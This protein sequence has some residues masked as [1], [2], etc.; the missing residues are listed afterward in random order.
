M[1]TKFIFKWLHSVFFKWLVIVYWAL[2][3]RERRIQKRWG[4]AEVWM[5]SLNG[6]SKMKKET[7]NK[8]RCKILASCHLHLTLSSPAP[9]LCLRILLWWKTSGQQRVPGM[10][11]SAAHPFI[12][13]SFSQPLFTL[14]NSLSPISFTSIHPIAL[15]CPAEVSSSLSLSLP[16]SSPLFHSALHLS[17]SYFP[18]FLNLLFSPLF[19]V[20]CQVLIQDTSCDPCSP[21]SSPLCQALA[22][23]F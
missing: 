18:F 7:N 16:P 12:H 11:P 23:F 13:P 5:A 10:Y 22:L 3:S 21:T 14:R 4:I 8:G 1:F 2:N 6:S 15:F 9:L 20:L 17:I 19:F